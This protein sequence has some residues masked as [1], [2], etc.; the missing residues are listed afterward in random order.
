MMLM[1]KGD[2]GSGIFLTPKGIPRATNSL[3]AF[4][5]VKCLAADQQTAFGGRN[6]KRNVWHLEGMCAYLH[7]QSS[8]LCYI[9]P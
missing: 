3:D 1:S 9:L 2:G 8:N 4:L 6:C 7:I 5:V